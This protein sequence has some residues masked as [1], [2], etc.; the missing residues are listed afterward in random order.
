M[1]LNNYL[2]SESDPENDP[3]LTEIIANPLLPLG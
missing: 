2:E 1:S 3:F